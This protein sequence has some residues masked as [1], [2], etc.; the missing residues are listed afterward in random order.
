MQNKVEM[1]KADLVAND[2]QGMFDLMCKFPDLWAEGVELSRDVDPG[3]KIDEI[4]HIVV[5]GMGG[6]AIGGDL[7]RSFV[8]QTASIPVFVNRSYELP[9]FVGEKTLFIASSYSGNTE[10]T[11]SAL[12]QAMERGAKV[13]C[14]T[15]GGRLQTVAQGHGFAHILIPGGLPPRAAL[16]YS[17]APQLALA[18]KLGLTEITDADQQEAVTLLHEGVDA[19]SN[20][21]G[22]EALQL[23]H[24]VK[25]HA[26]LVYSCTGFLDAVNVRWRG[27]FEEN[28]K[29]LAFGNV[30]PE[31][32]HNEIVGWDHS[33]AFLDK[34]G[35]VVLRD[36]DD[37]PRIQ[38]RIAVTRS[39]L[40]SKAA[41]WIEKS[42]S[43]NSRLARMLSL[44]QLGDWVSLYL[45][46]LNK[47]DPTP[48]PLIDRLKEALSK[49]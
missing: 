25:D 26:A 34:F 40:E 6:S 10:E 46:A 38:H 28:A 39:I 20:T 29:T 3:V 45:A 4:S 48:I 49:V 35:V 21:E 41:F 5:A 44:I 19:Y 11:L 47:V 30:F 31:L 17:F 1:T 36:R 7:M 23:A 16:P 43:G 24:T 33:K 14:I 22:N 2:S 32:N 8:E 9:A 37:H 27:Q 42:S 12:E 15:S 18:A 13:F